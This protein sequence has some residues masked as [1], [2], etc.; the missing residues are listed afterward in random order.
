[1]LTITRNNQEWT[2]KFWNGHLFSH[3]AIAPS[4]IA[5]LRKLA[6]EFIQGEAGPM[7]QLMADTINAIVDNVMAGDA[8]PVGTVDL[9]EYY[10]RKVA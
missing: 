4:P 3:K 6:D 9:A 8:L 1:M 5:A 2:A 7:V 10:Y